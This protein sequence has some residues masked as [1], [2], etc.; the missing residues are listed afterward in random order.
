MTSTHQATDFRAIA[1]SHPTA[2][3][4]DPTQSGASLIAA[5]SE[6]LSTHYRDMLAFEWRQRRRRAE[7]PL[8]GFAQLCEWD[9]R[10]GAYLDGFARL[11][12]RCDPPLFDGLHEAISEAELFALTCQAAIGRHTDL[13]RACV[14]LAQAL[15]A[16]A[17]AFSAALDWLDWPS[18][19]F[20][21]ALWPSEDPF[22]QALMLRVISHHDLVGEP[23][24]VARCVR[25]LAQTPT[26]QQ[27]ALRC[28]LDR[29]EADWALCAPDWVRSEDADVRLA[30]AQALIVFGADGVR[31][32]ALPALRDLALGS[33]GQTAQVASRELM[34]LGGQ[35]ANELLEALSADPSRRRQFIMALAWSG[36]LANLSSLTDLFDDPASARLAGA[37]VTILTGSS[38]VAD[39]WT[40]EATHQLPIPSDPVPDAESDRLPRTDPDSD[41]P[42][43]DRARFDR[44]P[45][46][47]PTTPDGRV[48]AGRPRHSGE[49]MVVLQEGQLATRPQA[50][51]LMQVASR[52]RRLPHLAPAPRQQFL[53][54]QPVDGDR[55]G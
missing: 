37:A 49:L 3:S 45:F 44:I 16:F 41:L 32:A 28:A 2:L 14:G 6:Q 34:T 5:S 47:A 1:P 23:D 26:V 54:K 4:T 43:P 9:A 25:R 17:P 29:G 51:W 35:E 22:R 38:A 27:A 48:L 21:L 33:S 19:E 10:I 7:S 15:P 52:G 30:A 36:R 24:E 8:H 12:Q 42:W 31:R 13:L 40:A 18:A 39:G 53:L 50:A 11:Q 20:A 46:S 55:N